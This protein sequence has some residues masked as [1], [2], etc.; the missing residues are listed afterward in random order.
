MATC[1][2]QRWHLAI[3]HFGLFDGPLAA[4]NDYL[5]SG[6]L[7]GRY[8]RTTERTSLRSRGMARRI[9]ADRGDHCGH[10]RPLRSLPT[11][12]V[13]AGHGSHGRPRPIVSD[14]GSRPL[15]HEPG[16]S[17]C[18]RRRQDVTVVT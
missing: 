13:T 2:R 7:N 17:G 3:R 8:V 9:T 5:T 14:A 1:A 16:G 12:A 4:A 11:T 10:G 6:R 15:R 18:A